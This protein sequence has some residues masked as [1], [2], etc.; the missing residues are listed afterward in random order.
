VNL[1]IPDSNG[2]VIVSVAWYT[3][4]YRPTKV[5]MFVHYDIGFLITLYAWLM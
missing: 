3:Y 5:E 1:V 4:T 2:Y